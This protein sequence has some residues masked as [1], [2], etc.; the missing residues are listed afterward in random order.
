MVDA[1]KMLELEARRPL[2]P[3]GAP[4]MRGLRRRGAEWQMVTRGNAKAGG[5]RRTKMRAI[6]SGTEGEEGSQRSAPGFEAA[7]TAARKRKAEYSVND[8]LTAM[9]AT[10][11]QLVMAQKQMAESQ[12]AFL[13]SNKAILN[14]NKA[15]L[16]SNQAMMETIKAQGDEIKALKALLQAIP[17]PSSYSEAIANSGASVD[18][19][20][21][22]A[23]STSAA[24]SQLRKKK[25]QVQDD[26]V[27]SID[28][29]RSK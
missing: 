7:S 4:Q 19:Q 24:S 23:R 15:L 5:A 16:E 10:I 25:P 21:S 13:K 28:M 22:Q 9:A 3:P 6:A 11:S 2:S 17:R 29:G 26:R 1:G 20:S 8:K 12:K 18:L 14:C 27:V